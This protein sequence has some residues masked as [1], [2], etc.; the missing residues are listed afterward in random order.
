M[1]KMKSEIGSKSAMEKTK[2][3]TRIKITQ[4]K[5]TERYDDQNQQ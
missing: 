2:R 4:E 5:M 3:E 1:E